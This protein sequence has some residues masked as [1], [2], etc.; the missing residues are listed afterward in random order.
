MAESKIESLLTNGG[1]LCPLV[2]LIGS[3]VGNSVTV[4][5]ED[6]TGSGDE[7]TE[8]KGVGVTPGGNNG[9]EYLSLM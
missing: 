8:L 4:V 5:F 1:W 2:V 3:G 6:K 9:L 7:G